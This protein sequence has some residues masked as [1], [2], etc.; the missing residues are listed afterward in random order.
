MLGLVRSIFKTMDKGLWARQAR[1]LQWSFVVVYLVSALLFNGTFV[2]QKIES[3][4]IFIGYFSYDAD[5][6][7]TLVGSSVLMLAFVWLS[8]VMWRLYIWLGRYRA[9]A[10]ATPPGC[11]SPWIPEEAVK[12]KAVMLRGVKKSWELARY[13]GPQGD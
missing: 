1:I 4:W 12:F 3:L 10:A 11:R 2:A 9:G 8:I 5:Y 13:R 7:V 6:F